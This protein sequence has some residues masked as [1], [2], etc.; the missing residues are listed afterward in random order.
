MMHG[1]RNCTQREKL[2]D[3]KMPESDHCL[4]CPKITETPSKTTLPNS[5]TLFPINP[6][7]K[8]SLHL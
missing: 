3:I 2:V 4:Q 7:L 6:S 5:E 8:I 1:R